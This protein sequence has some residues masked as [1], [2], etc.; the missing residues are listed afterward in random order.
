MPY[1][2]LEEALA[3]RFHT[4]TAYL[5]QIN[6]RNRIEAGSEIVVP[7]VVGAKPPAN[8]ASIEID[9]SARVLYVL[10]AGKRPLAAFPISIGNEKG[11]PL[12]IGVMTIKNEVKNP[13]FTYDPVLLKNQPNVAPKM[14]LPP[15]PNNPVGNMWLGLSKPHWGIHGTAVPSNVGHSETNGCIHLTNW[16]A[17][18]VSMMAKVGF[19]VEVRP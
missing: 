11:D 10:D 1:E 16:D 5:K 8:A 6:R 14:E 13:S 9:K 17:E 7:N 15:G 12:P 2:S 19:K 18:R 4:S 3:E